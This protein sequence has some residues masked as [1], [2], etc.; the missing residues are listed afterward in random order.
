MKHSNGS[1]KNI[2]RPREDNEELIGPEVSYLN[3]I[4]A[5]FSNTRLA[6]YSILGEF[7]SKI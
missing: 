3:V 6:T 2:F 5:Y 7:I 1:L 4:G